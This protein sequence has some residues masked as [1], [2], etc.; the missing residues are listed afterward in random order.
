MSGPDIEGDPR[1]A[2][3]PIPVSSLEELVQDPRVG[4]TTDQA[5]ID[6]GEK[7]TDWEGGE[8]ADT[9]DPSP[10]PVSPES[11]KGFYLTYSGLSGF[12]GTGDSRELRPSVPTRSASRSPS[13][14]RT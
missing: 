9:T 4:I 12:S 3:L 7:V 8:A 2:D 10:V 6:A 13:T 14:A 1:E 5:V 11:L